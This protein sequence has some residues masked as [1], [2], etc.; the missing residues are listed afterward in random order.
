MTDH[1]SKRALVTGGAGFIGSNLADRL[2]AAGHTVTL[3]DSLARPGTDHD[4][5]L[6]VL[7]ANDELQR[8]VTIRAA[9][10]D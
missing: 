9:F 5:R 1:D 4:L 3:Y 2:A 6:K 8:T 10:P 7:E